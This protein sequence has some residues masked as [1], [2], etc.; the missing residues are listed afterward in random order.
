MKAYKSHLTRAA[1]IIWL[2]ALTV[3]AVLFVLTFALFVGS[4]VRNPANPGLG[5]P[6]SERAPLVTS[7]VRVTWQDHVE[8]GS[9]EVITVRLQNRGTGRLVR[10]PATSQLPGSSYLEPTRPIGKPGAPLADAF[11][12][13]YEGYASAYL[14]AIDFSA[15]PVNV[16]S[17]PLDQSEIDWGWSISPKQSGQ[18][19]ALVRITG[20]WQPCSG[21]GNPINREI[22]T[23]R[24][25]K[26]V[27]DQPLLQRNSFDMVGFLTAT[28]GASSILLI[29]LRIAWHGLE[30]LWTWMRR[31]KKDGG[32]S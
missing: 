28:T 15:V 20:T 2:A 19:Y 32:A 18:Q 14:D 1:H 30:Q 8:V 13:T 16:D 22:W 4:R 27:V 24:P 10:C 29:F 3:S 17:E 21:S 23:S 5:H 6:K 9:S 12:P 7:T 25:I 11:G 31:R 26:I